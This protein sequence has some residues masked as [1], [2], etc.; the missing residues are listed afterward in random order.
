MVKFHSFI[1]GDSK[2]LLPSSLG[3]SVPSSVEADTLVGTCHHASA[4]SAELT[5]AGAVRESAKDLGS[6]PPRGPSSTELPPPP[7]NV[8]WVWRSPL[9][10]SPNTSAAALWGRALETHGPALGGQSWW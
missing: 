8:K 1:P 7:M 4:V 2:G 5:W 10:E 9:S 3:A 6:H